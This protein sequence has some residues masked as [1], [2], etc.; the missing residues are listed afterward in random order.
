MPKGT[1]RPPWL[2]CILADF[3]TSYSHSVTESTKV[4]ITFPQTFR[5]VSILGLK[6]SR[7]STFWKFVLSFLQVLVDIFLTE[8]IFLLPPPHLSMFSFC[9]GSLHMVSKPHMWWCSLCFKWQ[10]AEV[11]L[12]LNSYFFICKPTHA[13][14]YF[15]KTFPLL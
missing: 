11:I 10:H 2:T 7:D 13:L 8:I 5:K 1:I 12:Y 15:R 6:V 4:W 3:K 9:P 14:Y